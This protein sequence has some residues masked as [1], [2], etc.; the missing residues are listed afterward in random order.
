MERARRTATHQPM[1]AF[2]AS[3]LLLQVLCILSGCPSTCQA[4][5]TGQQVA[6]T[7]GTIPVCIQSAR[8]SCMPATADPFAPC[9]GLNH[10]GTDAAARR[11]PA[12]YACR[13]QDTWW[14]FCKPAPDDTKP[15]QQQLQ[16]QQ[17][18]QPLTLPATG[19]RTAARIKPLSVNTSAAGVIYR[20]YSAMV[21][22]RVL[23]RDVASLSDNGAEY[24]YGPETHDETRCAPLPHTGWDLLN[25]KC[26]SYTCTGLPLRW[27]HV[28]ADVV[29]R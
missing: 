2:R 9:G 4:A 16:K 11:C 24:Q 27:I 17:Q 12:G 5:C 10:G 13:R 26:M 6:C 22:G 3:V 21:S 28:V 18:Q 15:P 23:V 29:H 19:G 14:W 1:P 7:P 25:I 8:W 20:R